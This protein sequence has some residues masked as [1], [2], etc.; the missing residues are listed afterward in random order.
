MVYHYNCI[1]QN[2]IIN[3]DRIYESCTFFI[4]FKYIALIKLLKDHKCFKSLHC[5]DFKT[6]N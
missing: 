2:C 6:I 4:Y 1:L 5:L 3:L